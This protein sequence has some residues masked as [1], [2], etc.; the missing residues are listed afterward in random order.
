MLGGQHH[1]GCTVKCIRPRRENANGSV[2]I[3]VARSGLEAR[4]LRYSEIDFGAFAA[5][6]PIALEQFDSLRPIES[7]KFI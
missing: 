5:S 4:G 7:L 2:S 6:D 3:L 1:V